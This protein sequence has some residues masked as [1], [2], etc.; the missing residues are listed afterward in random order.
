[1]P[2][3]ANGLLVAVASFPV[4]VQ[5]LWSVK[6]RSLISRD[7]WWMS[8][9]TAVAFGAIGIMLSFLPA[10]VWIAS[11][12]LAT[13]AYVVL[14]LLQHMLN[15]RLFMRTI[16]EYVGVGVFVLVATLLVIPWR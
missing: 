12:F 4:M 10:T 5:G 3:W 8:L 7:T 2:F 6:L 14:G 11:L 1:L 13:V 9:V 16:Y 15:E